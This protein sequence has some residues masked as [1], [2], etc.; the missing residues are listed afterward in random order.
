MT[1][2][3][4]SRNEWLGFLNGCGVSIGDG[5]MNVTVVMAGFAARLGAPNWVI[6]LLPAIAGG[7]WMLPQLLVAARVRGLPYKLPVYRSAAFVRAATYVA[8]VLIAAAFA[9]RPSR[10]RR[11]A[12]MVLGGFGAGLGLFFLRNLTQVLGEAG[13]VPPAFAAFTP[14][15][16]AALLALTVLLRM[17]E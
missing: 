11:I 16:V 4:W 12:A 2:R 17:E 10:G 7:G 1:L 6:G 15:L 5:F 8:M 14:P 9:M 3:G 13:E